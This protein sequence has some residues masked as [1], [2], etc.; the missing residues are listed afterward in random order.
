MKLTLYALI[1][2]ALTACTVPGA[3]KGKAIV[4]DLAY[5]AEL[6][7]GFDDAIE[8]VTEA[9]KAEGFGIVS[10][11]DLHVTFK[12]K[13]GLEMEPHTI[14]GACN[15]KLAHQAVTAVPE[16]SLMLPCN[17]TVQAVSGGKTVVRLV[18]SHAMMAGAGFDQYPAVLEVGEHADKGLKRVAEAL[19][20]K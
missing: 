16:A 10:R 20:G 12:K 7:L 14:L 11:I 2:L 18:K 9:L 15:P 8:A 13:L 1:V 5:V 17:V 3:E 4:D 19:G 6:D